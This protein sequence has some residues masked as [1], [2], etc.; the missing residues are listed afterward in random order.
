MFSLLSPHCLAFQVKLIVRDA[1]LDMNVNN[2]LKLLLKAGIPHTV[3]VSTLRAL[4]EVR[5]G[6]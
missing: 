2:M 6:L 5:V 4:Q 3:H 1:I